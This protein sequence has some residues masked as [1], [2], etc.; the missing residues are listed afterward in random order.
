MM[1]FQEL[2]MSNRKRRDESSFNATKCGPLLENKKYWIW[3]A[4]DVE[5]K[6]IVGVYIGNRYKKGAIGLWDS[7]ALSLPSMCGFLYTR[8]RSFLA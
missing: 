6:E 7:N 2:L 5:T 3:L 8:Y 4:I 1:L